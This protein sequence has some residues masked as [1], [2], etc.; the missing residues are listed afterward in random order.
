M[1]LRTWIALLLAASLIG[2][3]GCTSREGSAPPDA[4]SE[5]ETGVGIQDSPAA[6]APPAERAKE[7]PA[8][9]AAAPPAEAAE[10]LP[11]PAAPPVGEPLAVPPDD[12]PP[13]LPTPPPG[14][15]PPS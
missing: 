1:S 5:P 9:E 7:L 13:P 11:A 4:A 2:T 14:G 6:A 10:D 12:G 3:A 8:P 15:S